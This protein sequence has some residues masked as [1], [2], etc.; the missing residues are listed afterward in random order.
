MEQDPNR[1][2]KHIDPETGIW[3]MEEWGS[4]CGRGFVSNARFGAGIVIP[5]T[6]RAK[7]QTSKQLDE[8]EINDAICV[9]SI[10]PGRPP[11]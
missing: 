4:A 1:P 9:H 11:R 7:K 3:P 5:R 6:N 10:S 2:D 8:K